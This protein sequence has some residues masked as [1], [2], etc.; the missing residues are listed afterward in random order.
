MPDFSLVAVDHHPDFDDLSLV[1]VDHDPFSADGMVQQARTQ[2]ESQPQRLATGADI[3]APDINAQAVA[4]D[5]SYNPD[6]AGGGGATPYNP[7]ATPILPPDQPVVDWSRYHRPF[8]E[9]KAAIY[10]P[11]QGIGNFA[12][13]ALM[14]IGM[15]PYIAN[16]L[17]SRLGNVLGSSPLGIAGSALD[18]IEAKRRD[19]LPGTVMAA[20][21]MIPG[22]KGVARGVADEAGAA[23]RRAVPK[24]V[25]L[26]TH[27]ATDA[28]LLASKS[29]G[30]YNPPVKSPRP[31][32]ADYP[33]GA[34]GE[35]RAPLTED[36]EGRPLGA[37]F[38]A[39][40]K[41][42]GGSDE[43][44]PPAQ[45]DAISTAGI[46]TRPEGYPARA[47]PGKTAGVYRTEAGP[48]GPVRSILYDQS[49][50][51]GSAHKVVAH[52]IG[53]MI[54]D[55]AGK[56]PTAGLSSELKPLYNT[57]NTGQERSRNLT[58]PQHFSYADDDV[59]REYIAE[60]IRAYMADPNYIKTVAPKTAARIRKFVN[61]N[62]RLNKVIQ[63]NSIAVP[64]GAGM[65]NGDPNDDR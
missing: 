32:E 49:L 19:D 52:E 26:A 11:T 63:F 39:G 61:R 33:A 7:S 23:L 43:A 36:I 20:A 46:G 31:F 6:S 10:T 38:I 2:P 22:A 9:L 18:L 51:E 50:G 25:A 14:G 44:I 53:H 60:A 62:P 17:T 12:A 24:D 29:A 65:M 37:P 58:G 27:E 28:D 48:L 30:M 55:L 13:D 35:V 64:V 34:S 59:P 47:L 5:A 57:L 21:G 40:R 1:P 41:V 4:F 16:D 54:D 15:Q 3:G 56:I 8:G 42:V 45:Y